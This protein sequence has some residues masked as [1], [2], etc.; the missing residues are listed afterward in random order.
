MQEDLKL[1]AYHYDLP[2]ESIAQ[3]PADKRDNSKLMVLNRADNS[4]QHCHF[5]DVHEFI[6]KGDV[7]VVNNTKVFPARLFGQKATG[8]KIEVFLLEFPKL[9]ES[10]THSGRAH[11]L[12][13]SSKRPVIGSTITI[14]EELRCQVVDYL[15]GGKAL[16]EIHFNED[17]GLMRCLEL[18]GNVPL[19]PY[20]N[21]KEGSTK[22]DSQ[23]YQT[24]YAD[25]PGAVAAPTAGL[26]F[27]QELLEKL[28]NKGVTIAEVTLHVGYGTFAP[29]R[30]S[31]ITRHQIHREYLSIGRDVVKKVN[32][33]KKQGG[34]IWAVG[35]TSVRALEFGARETGTLQ[36]ME[37]WCD[38][39]IYPG[40]TFKVVDNLITNFHLPDSSLMFLVSALCGRETL[41]NCYESAIKKGYRFFSYGDAMAII[42]S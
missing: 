33:T 27:T 28:R 29:V 39:Y 36:A 22:E 2:Q 30:E 13:K 11:G 40:F 41:L 12:L 7:L 1:A 25:Q 42:G 34:K 5:S 20:I 4:R 31:D 6:Q 37:D 38:L 21:R 9:L 15:E 26:H 3:R 35:T 18:A 24:V 14:N 23:R 32:D 16:L 8:G 10:S 19:P 17:L